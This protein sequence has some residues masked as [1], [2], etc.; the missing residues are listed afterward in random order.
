MVNFIFYFIAMWRLGHILSIAKLV[1]GT[2]H[3]IFAVFADNA[4]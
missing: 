4:P 2:Q 3:F 1:G